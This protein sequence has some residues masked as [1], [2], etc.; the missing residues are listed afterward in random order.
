MAIVNGYCTL[1]EMKDY[2]VTSTTDATD[3]AVIEDIIEGVSR[4]FDLFTG[5][6]FYARTETHTYDTPSDYE[7]W[8]GDDDLLTITTLT[9]GDATV[10][11]SGQY[12]LY[13]LNKNPKY[14]LCLLPTTGV[15]WDFDSNGNRE[16][17]ISIVGTW[18]YSA[19]APDDIKEACKREVN[20]RYKKRFGENTTSTA[21]ITAM[22]VVLA[23]EGFSK[24]TIMTLKKYERRVY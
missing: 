11:T 14:K 17:A 18:G 23:P 4:D 19:S 16:G 7:L 2:I 8:I 10:I 21:T 13:P 1:Q 22:G 6:T 5:R 9:N 24:E 20:S 15:Y 12:K 3:D